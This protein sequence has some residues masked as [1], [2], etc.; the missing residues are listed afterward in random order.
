MNILQIGCHVG[1]DDHSELIKTCESGVLIDANKKCVK[2]AE[3]Q[4]KDV[5]N[6]T[7]ETLAIIPVDIGGVEIN[8]F[9]EDDKETSPWASVNPNFV[10]AHCHHTNLKS[11]KCKTE[12]LSN[13]LRKYP[14]TDTLIIDTEGLDF[15]NIIS[16]EQDL[17][18]SIKTLTFEHIHCDGIVK[19]GPKLEC[20]IRFLQHMGFKSVKEETYNL[21]FSK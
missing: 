4:Y 10:A 2:E 19:Q 9:R 3:K 12:T 8:L 6:I 11:F 1:D 20:L 13:L 17:F 7:Y 16:I 5:K 21:V 15:L 14:K 18:E